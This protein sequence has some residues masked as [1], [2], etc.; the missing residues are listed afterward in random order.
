[1]G[2]KTIENGNLDFRLALEVM[3]PELYPCRFP[4]FRRANLRTTEGINL[5]KIINKCIHINQAFKFSP[6]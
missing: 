4:L 1:M 2:A 5:Q 3:N 6:N